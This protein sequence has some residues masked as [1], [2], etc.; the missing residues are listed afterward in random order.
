MLQKYITANVTHSKKDYS[1]CC[2][3]LETDKNISCLLL[4]DNYAQKDM[5]KNLCYLEFLLDDMIKAGIYSSR[6]S[7]NRAI[8]NGTLKATLMIIYNSDL[9]TLYTADG[10]QTLY[11]SNSLKDVLRYMTSVEYCYSVKEKMISRTEVYGDN[12][13]C[14]IVERPIS[15]LVNDLD[16]NDVLS[17]DHDKVVKTYGLSREL[18]E[19]YSLGETILDES[20][21]SGWE[22]HINPPLVETEKIYF[23]LYD[24]GRLET[25]MSSFACKCARISMLSPE[26]IHCSDCSKEEWLLNKKERDH[27]CDILTDDLWEKIKNEYCICASF[28]D[29]DIIDKIKS[30]PI[31]DYSKLPIK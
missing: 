19:C 25:T 26:Y 22:F 2:S 6:S 21:I 27:L 7:I 4:S 5:N 11:E 30:L 9:D 28:Y 8:K 15:E 31:P 12:S 24:L 16:K 10:W 1:F 20:S 17:L 14:D 18:G 29:K 3:K 23:Q 13:N